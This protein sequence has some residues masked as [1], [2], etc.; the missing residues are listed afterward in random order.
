MSD[1]LVF[2]KS[3]GYVRRR[4]S[5]CS[6]QVRALRASFAM[7]RSFGRLALSDLPATPRPAGQTLVAVEP[8]PAR[9]WS[10]RLRPASRYTGQMTEAT[11]YEKLGS[12]ETGVGG[13][14]PV[15]SADK[16]GAAE[17]RRLGT[18]VDSRL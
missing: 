7:L 15:G 6:R 17:E 14:R 18:E 8:A 1:L 2:G 11:L 12:P 5:L 4:G 9:L 13:L 10:D 16:G 3:C